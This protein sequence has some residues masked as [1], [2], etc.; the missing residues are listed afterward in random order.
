MVL[1]TSGPV[2]QS[3]SVLDGQNNLSI[4]FQMSGYDLKKIHIWV[5]TPD[6]RFP[7]LKHTDQGNVIIFLSKATLHILKITYHNFHIIA[8]AISICIDGAAHF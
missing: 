3:Q 4:R 5:L 1:C 7:I 2:F 6:I 8:F